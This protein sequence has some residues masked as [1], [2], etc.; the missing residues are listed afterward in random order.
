MW[1]EGKDQI[2][3]FEHSDAEGEEED[4]LYDILTG[5]TPVPRIREDM[6]MDMEEEDDGEAMM[7]DTFREKRGRANSEVRGRGLLD[8]SGMDEMF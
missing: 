3:R 6:N 1:P 7:D 2:L 4:S 8:E 5:K